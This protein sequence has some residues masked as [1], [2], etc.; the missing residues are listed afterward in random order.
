MDE[1]PHADGIDALYGGELPPEERERARAHVRECAL[2]Q[3]QLARV[4][5]LSGRIRAAHGPDEVVE[6]AHLTDLEVAAFVGGGLEDEGLARTQSHLAGC[7]ECLRLVGAVR[8][9]LDEH[10]FLFGPLPIE[11]WGYVAYAYWVT[12]WAL[13]TWRR[14]WAAA[15]AAL[16]YLG[17]A[18]L[19]ACVVVLLWASFVPGP[20]APD[21]APAVVPF[22]WLPD[23]ILRFAAFAVACLAGAWALRRLSAWL[24]SIATRPA[25]GLW[26]EADG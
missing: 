1:C 23:G 10:E 9:V 18:A 19:L 6:G 25:P 17:Q 20:W 15:G 3:T 5:W 4:T 24:W 16:L 21:G 13:S 7:S 12:R 8:R 14:A 26:G 2:C 22:V 11:R